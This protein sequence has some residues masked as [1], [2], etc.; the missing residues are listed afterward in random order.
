MPHPANADD[1]EPGDLLNEGRMTAEQA[2][3]LK[4]TFPHHVFQS[5]YQQ[6]PEAGGSG[7][8]NL[9][10]FPR[11]DLS[12]EQSYDFRVHSWDIGA[13]IAGNAS[14]CTKWACAKRMANTRHISSTCCVWSSSFPKSKP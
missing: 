10:I 13:T 3:E 12:V 5:Q 11:F 9:S 2:A 1:R 4:Q 8:L 6:N 7:M 14:V